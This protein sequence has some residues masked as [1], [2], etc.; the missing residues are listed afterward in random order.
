MQQSQI[1]TTDNRISIRFGDRAA[2]SAED[3][4]VLLS[5]SRATVFRLIASGALP[6]IKIGKRRLVPNEAIAAFVAAAKGG[7]I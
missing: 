6:S 7:A 1:S 3:A 4:A 5:I 2:Y